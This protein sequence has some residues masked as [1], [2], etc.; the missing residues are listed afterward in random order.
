MVSLCVQ[1]RMSPDRNDG[2]T[3]DLGKAAIRAAEGPP[4]RQSDAQ[5]Q[6]CACA[7][8]GCIPG[9]ASTSGSETPASRANGHLAE[10]AVV[11]S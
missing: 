1:L 3:R 11:A 5:A 4:D 9:A 6:R 7:C 2:L 8:H 10:L